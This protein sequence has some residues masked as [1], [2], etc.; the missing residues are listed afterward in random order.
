M[1]KGLTRI[2]VYSF[3]LHLAFFTGLNGGSVGTSCNS[4]CCKSVHLTQSCHDTPDAAS[5]HTFA[6]SRCRKCCE[7]KMVGSEYVINPS[8]FFV[9]PL[10]EQSSNGHQVHLDSLGASLSST[11]FP[12]YYLSLSLL[13]QKSSLLLWLIVAPLLSRY[14]LLPRAT[15]RK[16]AH[17]YRGL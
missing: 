3:V 11:D 7:E 5:C 15:V 17:C 12:L 6:N 10:Y 14:D 1:V 13:L 2:V 4:A 16:K 8:A 9:K